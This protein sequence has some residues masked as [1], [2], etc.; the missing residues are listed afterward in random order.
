MTRHEFDTHEGDRLALVEEDDGA[1]RLV[2]IWPMP[3]EEHDLLPRDNAYALLTLAAE[4]LRERAAVRVAIAA[5]D[6]DERYDSRY[7]SGFKAARAEALAIVEA[8]R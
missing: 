4:L 8:S 2:Q 6:I 1:L 3:H 5:L 7:R